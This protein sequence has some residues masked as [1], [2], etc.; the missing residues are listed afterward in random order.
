MDKSAEL[1]RMI[2]GAEELLTQL[3]DAHDPGIQ[4]LRDRIDRAI[5]DARRAFARQSGEAARLRDVVGAVDDYVR[6]NP[7]LAVGAGVLAAGTVAFI[8]GAL[9]GAGR[10]SARR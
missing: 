3:G 10:R 6:D 4:L 7:W 5:H 2:D 9:L 1:D 8:A